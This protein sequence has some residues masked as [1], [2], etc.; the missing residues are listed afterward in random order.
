MKKLIRVYSLGTT[1]G[2]VYEVDGRRCATALPAGIDTPALIMAYLDIELEENHESRVAS[3]VLA[4]VS[5][6]LGLVVIGAPIAFVTTLATLA[7]ALWVAD[8]DLAPCIGRISDA[9]ATILSS[10]EDRLADKVAS[11]A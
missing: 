11:V 4:I 2:A 3:P 8:S 5:V 1:L 9:S 7:L 10:Q 6:C